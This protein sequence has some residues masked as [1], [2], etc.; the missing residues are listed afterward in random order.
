MEDGGSQ[1]YIQ[2]GEAIITNKVLK[3]KKNHEKI[4]KGCIYVN[5]YNIYL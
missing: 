1:N 5:G 4:V 3:P 2:S